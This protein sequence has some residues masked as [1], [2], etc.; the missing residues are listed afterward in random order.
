MTN[1][2][3]KK[4]IFYDY[5]HSIILRLSE[6]DHGTFNYMVDPN[7]AHACKMKKVSIFRAALPDVMKCIVKI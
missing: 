4:I 5:N 3:T 6:T 1:K 7:V 2:T